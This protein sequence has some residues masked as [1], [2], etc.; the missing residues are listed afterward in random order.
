MADGNGILVQMVDPKQNTSQ[1]HYLS[2]PN[3][4]LQRFTNDLSLYSQCCLSATADG[5]ELVAI[6]SNQL[7]DAY[8]LPNGDVSKAKQITSGEPIFGIAASSA[9]LFAL[10]QRGQLL[11]MNLDGSNPTP[12]MTG[13]DRILSGALCP[14]QKYAVFVGLKGQANL[15]R[16]DV[17]GTNLKQLSDNGF[18]GNV[19]CSNDS[20]TV[21]YSQVS[22]TKLYS[23]P[24]DGGSPE[25]VKTYPGAGYV[26][27]SKDGKYAGYLHPDTEQRFRVKL[28]LFDIAR[29]KTIRD[30]EYP[31]G[32]D[33]P[34]FSPDGKS[35]Q[36]MLTRNGAR[37]V[38]AQP[39][40]G[41][42]LRQVTFF[43]SGDAGSYSWSADGKQLYMTHGLTKSDVVLITAFEQ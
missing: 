28:G 34:T 24:I 21:Y 43:S 27:F 10:N 40:D 22:G 16:I 17:D 37:N 5:K 13:F 20:K 14:D 38:W 32:A 12:L 25:E 35:I 31:L 26:F 4:Q 15:W 1:I 29:G 18:V 42:E 23:V 41:G 2:Y 7:S 19:S 30:F 39:I 9:K 11:A 36:L 33:G 6:Q 8:V 3:A